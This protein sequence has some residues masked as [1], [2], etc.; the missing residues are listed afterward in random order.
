M[1]EQEQVLRRLCASASGPDIRGNGDDEFLQRSDRMTSIHFLL[2]HESSRRTTPGH[3]VERKREHTAQ[4][5][6]AT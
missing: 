3:I 1:R 5:I 2:A 4:I 6:H